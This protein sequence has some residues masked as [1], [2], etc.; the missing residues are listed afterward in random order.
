MNK[1][2]TNKQFLQAKIIIKFKVYF[3]TIKKKIRNMM[4]IKYTNLKEYNY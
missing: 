4:Y 1:K 2:K 3:R